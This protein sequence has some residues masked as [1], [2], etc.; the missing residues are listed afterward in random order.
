MDVKSKWGN[1]TLD[2]SLDK[3]RMVL[4]GKVQQVDYSYVI[5]SFWMSQFVIL[6]WNEEYNND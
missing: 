6:R 5:V 3:L 1:H 2:I 4:N